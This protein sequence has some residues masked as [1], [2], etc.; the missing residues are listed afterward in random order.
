MSVIISRK[1]KHELSKSLKDGLVVALHKAQPTSSVINAKKITTISNLLLNQLMLDDRFIQCINPIVP[2]QPK[3]FLTTEDAARL[4][5]FSRPFIVALLDGG[6]YSGK[7][8][9][10]PKGHRR[11]DRNEFK[12]WIETINLPKNLPKT[13]VEVR[14]GPRDQELLVSKPSK[15]ETNKKR[16]RE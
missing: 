3:E 13:I 9:R 11:L 12:A 7:V 14:S 2:D 4:S 15:T 16:L 10:T 6:H 5:G 8:T 1:T